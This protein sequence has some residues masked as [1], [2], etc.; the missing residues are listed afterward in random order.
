MNALHGILR[1]GTAVRRLVRRTV[2]VLALGAVVL[3]LAA[4]GE[5]LEVETPDIIDP[6]DVRSPAGADAV[7]IGALARFNSATSGGESLFL[8]GGLFADEWMSG[9]TFIDR[10]QIDQR[11][12]TPRNTFLATAN[13]NLHRARLSAEQAV[14]LTEQYRQTAPRWQLAEMHFVQ[15]YT[16]NLAAEHYCNGL[17][18]SS[19][20]D[21]VETYGTPITTEAAFQ[22]ALGHADDGLAL[23]TGSTAADLRVR[24]ALQVTR[25]RILMNLNRPA[26]A[27]TAVNGVPT[28]Y[29]YEMFHSQATNS[30]Q[31]WNWNNLARRYT[32]ANNE[33]GNG[34]D[35][36]TANDPRV[37]TCRGGQAA[38]VAVGVT[39]ANTEDVSGPLF[40][41]LIWPQRESPVAIVD[42]INARMIEAEAQMRANNFTGALATMNAARATVPGLAPL[43]DPG[44][45]AARVDL[46][47]R[48]RAFWFFG[49][50]QRVGDMRRLIRQYGRQPNTVFPT[51]AWHKGGAYSADVNMPLPLE[52]ANNPNIGNEQSICI[53]RG[54]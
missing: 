31:T 35:F 50:G 11:A 27:A 3:P 21:G 34:M 2:P 4:C 7:R 28:T 42:G 37:P 16:V 49:R 45:D 43:T 13:R 39:N 14:Q 32:V 5:L 10:Q 48:E 12:I 19:V 23:I 29:Q 22:R 1:A 40:A 25:G 9:D 41:Q 52:E 46:L 33:G 44:T 54:A 18:F 36:V 8:L 30:N 38:C 15:A 6:N 17:V 24:H 53:D 47:F 51:G 26:E 20:V